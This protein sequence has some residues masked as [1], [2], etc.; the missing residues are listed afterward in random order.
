MKRVA[1]LLLAV[2]LV[3]GASVA[4]AQEAKKE[5][6]KEA[7]TP[8]TLTGEIVDM[9]C[10]LGHGAKGPDH[11]SC[12]LM[13]IEGGMP[14]GLLT[15]DNTLYL[16]TMSHDNAD[17]FNQAKK[18]AADIVDLTGVVHEKD[19]MKSIEVTG[20]TEAKAKAKG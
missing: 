5:M 6:K 18:M 15:S 9:G 20:I 11:K 2:S 16:L 14:M 13:C 4:L 10:Y 7:P 3:F 12:A 8:T 17:P 1:G 19:G